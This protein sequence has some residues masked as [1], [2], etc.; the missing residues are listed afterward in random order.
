MKELQKEIQRQI[1]EIMDSY[2]FRTCVKALSHV[3][4]CW[5]NQH[6]DTEREYILRGWTRKQLEAVSQE[7]SHKYTSTA[8][9]DG[10]IIEDVFRSG[11]FR[12]NCVIYTGDED[13]PRW[14]RLDV[15]CEIEDTCHDGVEF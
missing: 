3:E 1:N 4:C 10:Q 14:V 5:L 12:V 15:V 8:H 13:Q 7:A 9:N 6:D 2:D 11:C